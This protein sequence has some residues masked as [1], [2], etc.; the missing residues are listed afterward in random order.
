MHLL[1]CAVPGSIAPSNLAL[2]CRPRPSGRFET[3]GETWGL[4]LGAWGLGIETCQDLE[5][6]AG[7]HLA[8]RALSRDSNQ[9]VH[10]LGPRETTPKGNSQ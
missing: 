6:T 2:P 3:S 4:R 9:D 7:L 10:P 5:A 8:L 1:D